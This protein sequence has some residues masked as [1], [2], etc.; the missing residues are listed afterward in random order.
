MYRAAFTRDYTRNGG[1]KKAPVCPGPY[2]FADVG[3]MVNPLFE[4]CKEACGK[5]APF[6]GTVRCLS[7]T[8]RLANHLR[9]AYTIPL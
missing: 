5:I 3:K 6:L 4:H 2:H 7:I 8:K 9:L 1:Q